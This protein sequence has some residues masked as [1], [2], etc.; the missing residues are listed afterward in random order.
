M[1]RDISG[2]L[3]V[4]VRS[5]R[6]ARSGGIA[7]ETVSEAERNKVLECKR[8]EETDLRVGLSKK[9]DPKVLIY[10]VP[11][12]MTN[13]RLLNEMY[14]KNLSEC[15]TKSELDERV[16]IVNRSNRK[17]A[18]VG[19]VIMEVTVCMRNAVCKAGRVFV[20]WSAFRMKEFTSVLRCYKCFA[21]GHMMRE[22]AEKERLCQKC[23]ESGHQMKECKKECVC[24]NCKI[25]GGEWSHSVMSV[26][27]P[28]YVKALDKERKR[29]SDG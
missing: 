15:V 22:C 11:N 5:V 24:R 14:T 25:R 12:E 27:C 19:N 10:D 21:F 17:D 29:V 23:G 7:I 13:E 4:R 3:N 8:F 26:E 20:G 28:V 2:S 9:I 16:R 6:R 18:A 1:L